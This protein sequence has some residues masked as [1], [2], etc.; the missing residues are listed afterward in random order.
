MFVTYVWLIRVFVLIC[1]TSGT[2]GVSD[3]FQTDEFPPTVRTESGANWNVSGI[4][5]GPDEKPV[6]GVKI[7][8]T[9]GSFY[10]PMGMAETGLSDFVKSDRK[11]NFR[12][13]V[14]ENKRMLFLAS[15]VAPLNVA[16]PEGSGMDVQLSRGRTISGTI[17]DPSGEPSAGADVKP[18]QWLIP[19]PENQQVKVDAKRAKY[20][21]GMTNNIAGAFPDFGSAQAVKTDQEGR[22]KIK[23]LP[24]DFRVGLSVKV[25]ESK[26]E[27]VFV[28]PA[29]D[30]A[31]PDFEG[32]VLRDD[33]F[34][35][36]A[37][38]GSV[39]KVD[40]TDAQTGQPAAIANVYVEG[41]NSLLDSCQEKFNS[42]S[43]AVSVRPYANG[44][45]AR[46]EP[47]ESNRLLGVRVQLPPNGETDIITKEVQFQ[48]GKT[49]RG[50]VVSS[51]TG[52]PLKGVQIM[53]M[54]LEGQ[55]L[56]DAE[57]NFSKYETKTDRDG[58]FELAVPDVD[59][60]IGVIGDVPG[61]RSV[62]N[63]ND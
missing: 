58:R 45:T 62:S 32:Q 44:S 13:E 34:T 48:T 21:R 26:E 27:L 23:N 30:V 46:I 4:I 2:M 33:D 59:G 53:C 63:W 39:L 7:F 16:V 56:I 11:G 54:T 55:Q 52:D 6:S 8:L 38:A 9:Y 5:T 18:I 29:D 40:A 1:L 15:G 22:F 10:Q 28:R 61:H 41:F 19:K 37:E 14:Q 20:D 31:G 25:A 3:A 36:Q 47:K 17:L 24:E 57:G 35:F 50:T 42:S 60:I 51:V 49:V 43:V 12:T